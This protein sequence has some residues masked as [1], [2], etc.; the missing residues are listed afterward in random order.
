MSGQAQGS[1][2]VGIRG[3][4][5]LFLTFH[6][7]LDGGAAAEMA[8][9]E[10]LHAFFHDVGIAAAE[11]EAISL[12]RR[13]I[14]IN[15]REIGTGRPRTALAEIRPHVNQIAIID[16]FDDD[17]KPLG[18]I[19]RNRRGSW[20]V[21]GRLGHEVHGRTQVEANFAVLQNPQ[22]RSMTFTRT[23]ETTKE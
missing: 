16:S 13:H 22:L 5:D 9:E 14:G 18:A 20:L 21:H 17:G 7:S 15:R 11:A 6:A 10:T 1:P 4:S 3:I 12:Y 23:K 8:A 2:R 19:R